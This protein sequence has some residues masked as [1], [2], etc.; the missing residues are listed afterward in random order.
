M[1]LGNII[2]LNNNIK[3]KISR[4][5]ECMYKMPSF[6]GNRLYPSSVAL[7]SPWSPHRRTGEYFWGPL[8]ANALFPFELQPG[9]CSSP[10]YL[11]EQ[12]RERRK[13]S[14]SEKHNHL[15]IISRPVVC[16]WETAEEGE[17]GKRWEGGRETFPKASKALQARRE[18]RS[19]DGGLRWS[20]TGC[21]QRGNGCV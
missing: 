20:V 17:P 19:Q 7:L 4:H 11:W 10:S 14:H 5:M 1:K 13:I 15:L 6:W 18:G 3:K 9:S 12:T 8:F 16:V 2:E 21:S